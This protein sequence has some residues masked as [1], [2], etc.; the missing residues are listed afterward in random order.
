MA[1]KSYIGFFNS[2]CNNLSDVWNEKSWIITQVATTT[3]QVN[4]VGLLLGQSEQLPRAHSTNPQVDH[5]SLGHLWKSPTSKSCLK[6]V[7]ILFDITIPMQGPPSF[8]G[9]LGQLRYQLG[10]SNDSVPLILLVMLQLKELCQTETQ[11]KTLSSFWINS[12][13]IALGQ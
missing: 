8:I 9:W 1:S 6:T 3:G 10:S 7:T 13:Y 11:A 5:M 4:I 12:V 2:D